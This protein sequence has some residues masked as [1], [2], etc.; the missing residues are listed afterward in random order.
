MKKLKKAFGYSISV[1][2]IYQYSIDIG[3]L[4]V[5]FVAAAKI[6]EIICISAIENIQ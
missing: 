2:S 6:G 5:C 1:V 3:V 4:N